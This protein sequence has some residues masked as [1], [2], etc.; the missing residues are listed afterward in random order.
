MAGGPQYR[1][2]PGT[3]VLVFAGSFD[4]GGVLLEHGSK[5]EVSSRVETLS[6]AAA[7]FSAAQLEFN[8]ITED[9]RRVQLEL[10]DAVAAYLRSS[11]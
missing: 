4:S 2:R 1:L 5:A 10:Y 7:R 11:E 6:R 9:D 3:V 8:E